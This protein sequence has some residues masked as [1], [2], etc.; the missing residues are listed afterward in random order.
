MNKVLVVVDMQNDFVDGAL[1]TKEA[2]AIVPKVASKIR[3]HNG[4]VVYTQDTHQLEYLSTQEGKYLPVLH[5]IENTDGWQI[6]DEIQALADKNEA[7][8][9]TKDTFGSKGLIEYLIQLNERD[10]IDEIQFIGLC[11]DICVISNALAIKAY[12]PEVPIVVDEACCA[13]VTP[14]SHYN[15]INAMKVCHIE[16]INS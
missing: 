4:T 10:R 3:S 7:K 2:V 11:T 13:G 6:V 9:F 12:F 16:I 1:G 15:A 14:A 5:C 8:I